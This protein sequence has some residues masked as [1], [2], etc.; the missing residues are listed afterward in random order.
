VPS[1]LRGRGGW[2]IKIIPLERVALSTFRC[3]KHAERC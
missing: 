1:S 3:G 2:G